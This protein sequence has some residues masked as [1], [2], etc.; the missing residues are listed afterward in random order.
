MYADALLKPWLDAMRACLPGLELFDCHNHVGLRDPSG[1]TAT[2]EE[3]TESLALTGGRS[4]VMPAAEPDGYAAANRACA[5][6][7]AGEGSGLAAFTRV[8]P[9]DDPADMLADGLAHGARGLKL[10]PASDDF[11][12]EDPRLDEVYRM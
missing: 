10:H 2:L 7:A 5:V 12:L 3:L 9:E 11:R 8:T 1:F 6:A 4:V